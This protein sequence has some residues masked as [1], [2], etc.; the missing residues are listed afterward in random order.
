[1]ERKRERGA[2]V[3]SWLGWSPWGAIGGNSITK[4]NIR[5]RRNRRG[6]GGG[7]A[8]TTSLTIYD[9]NICGYNSKK[10]SIDELLDSEH[11]DICTFQE[12]GL[13]GNN[14]KKIKNYH[15]SLRNRKGLKKAGG[16]CT[17]VANNLKPFVV[18][19]KEGEDDDE[20]LITRLD[21]VHPALNIVKG[22]QCTQVSKVEGK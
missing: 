13:F 14:A 11:F 17:A 19:V 12:T 22:L 6:G 4:C 8:A 15:C 7:E 9:C 20:Y 16:I 18:K 3:G 21:N 5:R 10:D 2:F 1:M